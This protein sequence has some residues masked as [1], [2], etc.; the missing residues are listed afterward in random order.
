MLFAHTKQVTKAM[1]ESLRRLINKLVDFF[2]CFSSDI[3]GETIITI[4]QK[5]LL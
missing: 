1:T 2:S 4:A 5:S 3:K